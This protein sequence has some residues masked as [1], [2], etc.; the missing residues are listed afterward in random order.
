[1]VGSVVMGI[2][3]KTKLSLVPNAKGSLKVK[4][5]LIAEHT[6]SATSVPIKVGQ[7]T[8]TRIVNHRR[9][10]PAPHTTKEPKKI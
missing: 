10:A 3:I 1:M 8:T 5:I 4:N 7:K 2:N 9:L 6:T